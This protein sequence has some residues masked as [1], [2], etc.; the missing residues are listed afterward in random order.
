LGGGVWLAHIVN[1]KIVEAREDGDVLEWMQQL[2]M[3]L[4]PKYIRSVP[5]VFLA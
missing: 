3:E 4:K 2:G 5:I 1:G